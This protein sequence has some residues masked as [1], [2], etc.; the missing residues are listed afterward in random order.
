MLTFPHVYNDR[1][2]ISNVLLTCTLLQ[3]SLS[4]SDVK[5]YDN[6]IDSYITVS[7]T[8]SSRSVQLYHTT[9]C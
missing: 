6:S 8:D 4:S 2:L 5:L 3:L 7:G 9:Q 1:Y